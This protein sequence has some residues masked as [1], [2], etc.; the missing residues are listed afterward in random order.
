MFTLIC[1][2][3]SPTLVS[4]VKLDDW[5]LAV[6][7]SN[8]I[9]SWSV[10]SWSNDKQAIAPEEFAWFISTLAS[11]GVAVPKPILSADPSIKIA[12]VKVFVSALKSTEA[13]ESLNVNP[14]PSKS[15]PPVA[16]IPPTTC[17]SVEGE[18]VFI[19][20]RSLTGHIR[21][22]VNGTD[23]WIPFYATN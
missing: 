5:S 16:L 9:N 21:V 22:N 4:V 1:P 18:A 23:Y 3:K 8:L 19:P 17:N 20:I 2:V 13:P 10:S 11:A 15:I 6:V 14:P 12:C 7:P